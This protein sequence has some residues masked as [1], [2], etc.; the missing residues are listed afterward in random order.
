MQNPLDSVFV[1]ACRARGGKHKKWQVLWKDT[2]HTVQQPLNVTF[3]AA[4]SY[5]V[6]CIERNSM[7]RQHVADCVWKREKNQTRSPNSETPT[8]C[9]EPVPPVTTGFA[10][11]MERVAMRV[12]L[13]RRGRKRRRK[14][15]P[16]KQDNTADYVQ[17]RTSS[18]ESDV[19]VRRDTVREQPRHL[20]NNC[21]KPKHVLWGRFHQK[22]ALKIF[23]WAEFH[24][25]VLYWQ[26]CVVFKLRHVAITTRSLG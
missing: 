16:T 7:K 4:R 8:A 20:G 10:L 17:L 24:W 1:S 21:R 11:W 2:N 13:T 6:V 19:R 15:K 18:C 25:L 23:L 9:S 22:Q 12:S 26:L 5:S 14:K 3:L